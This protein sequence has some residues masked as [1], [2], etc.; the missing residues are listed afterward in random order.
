MV[1]TCTSVPSRRIDKCRAVNRVNRR[2]VVFVTQ[3]A[4][5]RQVARHT[6]AVVKEEVVTLRAQ[7]LGVI[8]TR[9]AGQQRK[10]QQQI[11]K[12]IDGDL[13]ERRKLKRPRDSTSRK[14]F[15]WAKRMSP[16][17]FIRWLPRDIRRRVENL[18]DVFVTLFCGLLPSS[19]SGENPVTVMKLNPKSRGF[20]DNVR[21]AD[22]S[23]DAG[24]LILLKDG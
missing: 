19:P 22:S 9:A 4:D 2:R 21:Q 8:D 17:N 13:S 16:P 11:A 14:A 23:I 6:K 20:G 15:C 1:P 18:I 5:Q 7:V 3:S 12:R 10:A 24:A